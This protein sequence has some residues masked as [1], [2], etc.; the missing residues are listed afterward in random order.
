VLLE[1][2]DP[3]GAAEHFTRALQIN[4]EKQNSLLGR[5]ISEYRMGTLDAA[6]TDLAHAAQLAPSAQAEFWLGRTLENEGQMQ[7]AAMAYDAALKIAPE[8]VEARQRLDALRAN[9]KTR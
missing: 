4:P 9:L 7:L 3:K 6:A 2:D 1:L 8:M 5:G